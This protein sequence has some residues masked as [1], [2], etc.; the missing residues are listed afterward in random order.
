MNI[1]KLREKIGM[2]LQINIPI[3]DRV[4]SLDVLYTLTNIF[5][6]ATPIKKPTK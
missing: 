4:M 3:H 6:I 5:A 2:I 1:I